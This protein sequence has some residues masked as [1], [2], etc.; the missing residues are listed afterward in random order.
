MSG[1]NYA[2]ARYL[3]Y[4]LQERGL[5]FRFYKELRAAEDTSGYTTLRAILGNPDMAVFQKEWEQ[6]VLA[7]PFEG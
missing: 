6:F 5:L 2:Q 7:I 4:Y 1:R 3:C